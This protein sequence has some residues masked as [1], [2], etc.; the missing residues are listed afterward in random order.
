MKKSIG[1]TVLLAGTVLAVI[2]LVTAVL[3]WRG[4][5]SRRTSIKQVIYQ[6]GSEYLVVEALDDDLIHFEFTAHPT[7]ISTPGQSL[8]TSPMVQKNDYEGPLR[9]RDNGKGILE[10]KDLKIQIDPRS[11][12]IAVTDKTFHPAALLATTCPALE[13]PTTLKILTISAENTGYIYG[14]GEQFEMP[15]SDNL[16]WLGDKRAS[17]NSQGN[18]MLSFFGGSVGNAQFPILYALDNN[19]KNFAMFFDH[20]Y[21][22]RW[23]FD[24]NPWELRTSG[25]DLHWYFLSGP[26]LPDLRQDYMEM[27][28]NPP[29]PPKK[30]FGLWISEYGF[31]SW[32]EL[33]DVLRT[34]QERRFPV[35]GA[36]MDLQWFGGIEPT[37]QSHM[38]S[39]R[40]DTDRFPEPKAKIAALS[41]QGIGLMTIEESY[42]AQNL[43][44]FTDLQR[45]GYLVRT[46]AT[47]EA[48]TLLNQW[49][50][51]GGMMDWTNPGGSDYW[52][53]L[54]RQPLIDMGILGYWT[55]LGEPEMYNSGSYYYGDPEENLHSQ[56]DMHNLY[57]F[58]WSESIAR[59]Y[60]RNGVERRPFIL[61]R[62]G[63]SGIQRF[64]AVMWSG[65][66]GSNLVSLA[67]H[68]T[69]HS[70][71][72][73]SG[74]DYFSSDTGGF[75]R[76]S[77][78]E[79]ID[80]IYT[81]WLAVSVL[82]DVPVRPHTENLCNCKETAPDRV[83]DRLSNLANVR[84][85]YELLPY[86]YSLA[87]LAYWK[88]EPV[89]PALVFYYQEDPNVRSLAD[90]KLIGRSLLAAPVTKVGEFS[91]R[92]YLPAGAWINYHSLEWIDS[93]GEWLENV[94]TQYDGL[95]RVPLFVRAGSIL[96]LM[97]VDEQTKNTL[98][99]RLDQ[100][101]HDEL[102]MRVFPSPEATSFTIYEDDGQTIAYQRGAV[103]TTRI[104]QK[105][106]GSK[107]IVT[108]QAASG[109]YAEAPKNRTN[110]VQIVLQSGS[111]SNVRL[112]GADLPRLGS[113]AEFET[114]E[115]GWIIL[116]D[117]L[118]L[119]KSNRI[120]V[121]TAKTF[122][123][124]L[125][126]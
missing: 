66:I 49:W 25:Q 123:F 42:I 85:R 43:P 12:C 40:W 61:S 95:F 75:H 126:Q 89:S 33:D 91:R 69:A 124:T 87:H 27:V 48:S 19:G 88:A 57:N 26:D 92:V 44:E 65:D 16:N 14:L 8:P 31:D 32:Q 18:A 77:A 102:I 29:V 121:E 60:Q 104:D 11:L 28:G 111:V 96:P 67:A 62:S 36:V 73:F 93:Q 35:D 99:K 119:A 56:N 10:T 21:A 71:M 98:G 37:D 78:G 23:S 39:L 6:A 115:Q 4:Q 110:I 55:D 50:G 81:K 45:R 82:F 116:D 9:F 24:L 52:H 5:Q 47:C 30:M 114:A 63:T 108:I 100:E 59:G 74:M 84:L 72:S 118:A 103:R 107:V 2:L 94:S 70:H 34:L 117:H 46:C 80:E 79:N 113:Q 125:E 20:P 105:M 101:K 54:K 53:D 38:G 76:Y 68:V 120:A 22:Q 109:E 3:L 64:G 7:N 97:Y 112:D 41:K 15:V 58:A 1:K 86:F 106:N 90:E 51:S 13:Q 17:T 122:E 83:G